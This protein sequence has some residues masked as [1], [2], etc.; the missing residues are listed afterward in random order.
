M[1][2]GRNIGGTK[3]DAGQDTRDCHN[4]LK[5]AIVSI[6]LGPSTTGIAKAFGTQG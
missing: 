3:G 6:D 2:W 4:D 1:G 5:M